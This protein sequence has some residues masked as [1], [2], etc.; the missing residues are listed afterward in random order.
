[1]VKG[2][3]FVVKE[4][5]REKLLASG[6]QITEEANKMVITCPED[7]L[8]TGIK[9]SGYSLIRAKK[10]NDGKVTIYLERE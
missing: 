1:L 5:M 6:C 9:I 8:K 4:E 3:I 7:V 10:E 2:E